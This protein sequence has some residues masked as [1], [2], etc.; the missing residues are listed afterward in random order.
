[1][2]LLDLLL[3]LMPLNLSSKAWHLLAVVVLSACFGILL[4]QSDLVHVVRAVVGGPER[5]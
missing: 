3:F 5:C 1:M 2:A 4:P